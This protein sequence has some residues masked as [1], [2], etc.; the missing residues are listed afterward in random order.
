MY[1]KV[2]LRL[3]I[4]VTTATAFS[5]QSVMTL[6]RADAGMATASEAPIKAAGIERLIDARMLS[7]MIS[8]ALSA[9]P[10]LLR[11]SVGSR[12]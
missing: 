12:S 10:I 3:A 6:A 9:R 5:S 4:G 7:S 8:Y 11:G 2:P 1:G